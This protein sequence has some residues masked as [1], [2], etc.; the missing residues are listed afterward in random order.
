[1]TRINDYFFFR[2]L[3]LMKKMDANSI[4]NIDITLGYDVSRSLKRI[5]FTLFFY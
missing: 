1:M 2:N 3:T 4:L 5:C